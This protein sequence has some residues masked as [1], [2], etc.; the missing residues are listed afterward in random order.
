[1]CVFVSICVGVKMCMCVCVY[2]SVYI[3][4]CMCVR[5]CV[6][7]CARICV[8]VCTEWGKRKIHYYK[9]MLIT[10]LRCCTPVLSAVSEH[11]LTFH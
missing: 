8:H 5:V 9:I 3:S 1:M 4:V 10:S 11:L 6:Y 7:V 2:V